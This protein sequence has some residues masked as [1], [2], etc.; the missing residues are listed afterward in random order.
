MWWDVPGWDGVTVRERTANI[1]CPKPSKEPPDCGAHYVGWFWGIRKFLN[2]YECAITPSLVREWSQWSG[3]SLSRRDEGI[4]YAMDG[5]FRD[6]MP[7]IIA[8]HEDR[9]KR[10]NT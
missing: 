10:E 6:T 1:D 9:R 3:I 5:A 4:I 8:H 7:K 2:G